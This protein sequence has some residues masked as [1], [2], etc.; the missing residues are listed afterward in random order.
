MSARTSSRGAGTRVTLGRRQNA[1]QFTVLV[2]VNALVG[3]MLG[4][5]PTV[6]PLLGEQ[7][8][9]LSGYTA[10]LAFIGVFGLSKAVADYF[11]GTWGDRYGRKPAL[12]AGWLVAL[13]V[14]L[15]PIWDR[16]GDG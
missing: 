5:E 15:L 2:V 8:F 9:G 6:V 13:P 7:E 4:Q 16:A 10:G 12:I 14:P 3:G 11:A 1:A